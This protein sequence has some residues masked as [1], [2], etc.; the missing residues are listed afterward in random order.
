VTAAAYF[1]PPVT[2]TVQEPRDILNAE[3]GLKALCFTRG[4]GKH[5]SA[6]VEHLTVAE[7]RQARD[8]I[9]AAL[10]EAAP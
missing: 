2:V 3:A 1:R 5:S 7:L 8:A 6:N 9:D 4:D 10:T